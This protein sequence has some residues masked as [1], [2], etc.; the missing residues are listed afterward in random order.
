MVAL[1][2]VFISYRRSDTAPYAARLK[3]HLD[4]AFGAEFV[5]MDVD[6]L[7]PGEPFKD[8]IE[9]TI[10]SIDV[11]LA[12]IGHDWL[13]VTDAGGKR[14]LENPGDFVRLEL[15]TAFQ[16]D[17]VVIPVLLENA[18]MPAS[19]ELPEPLVAL[20][21]RHAIEDG[22]RGLG[23]G[24]RAPRA[25][26]RGGRRH[27]P[28]LPVPGHGA[29]REK[30][31]GAI[32]RP[33]AG[34]RRD[35]GTAGVAAPAVPRRPVRV[36]QVVAAR[37]GCARRP[38]EQGPGP[39][40]CAHAAARAPRRWAALGGTLGADLESTSPADGGPTGDRRAGRP[41]GCCSSSTSSRSCSRRR[42]R[43]S[44][45]GS[46]RALEAIHGV[47][48]VSIVLA[49]RADFYGELMESRLWPLVE[50]GKVDVPPLTGDALAEA[51]AG[52][53]KSSHVTLE[54]DLLERLVAD[55]GNEP[56]ALPLLQEALVRL[57]GTMRLHRISL[58]AYESIG[59]DG[60][61]GLSAAVA[62]TA[63]AALA[64]LSPDEAPIAKRVLLRLVQFGQG[65]PDTRRQL[66]FE[67]LRSEGDDDAPL[68]RVLD[69]LADSRLVTLSAATPPRARREART[70]TSASTSPTR[71]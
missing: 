4:A 35:Q 60:R 30:G 38:R 29:V 26:P 21:Q 20:A 68:E 65:R 59:G 54:P 24:R 36:R 64:T 31:C 58:A 12:L 61:G 6:S 53:A 51:I 71:R 41:G 5:F 46:S 34:D 47:D 40:G 49:I 48:G 2:G 7:R 16:F 37:G 32:L 39:L 22:R 33:G 43:T 67:D 3:A 25:A 15:A 56:G 10:T 18:S 63:D 13:T 17:R 52:P 27:D 23:R 44:R 55:A 45:S 8:V 14:R 1:A 19:G 69:V 9:A 70:P 50:G 42:T 11:V 57:W 28:A 62:D 66:R